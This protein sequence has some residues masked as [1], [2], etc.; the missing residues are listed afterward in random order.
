MRTNFEQSAR[1]VA[2]APESTDSGR[3]RCE[4]GTNIQEKTHF[5]AGVRIR[6]VRIDGFGASAGA[7]EDE[8]RRSGKSERGK[9]SSPGDTPLR[10]AAR[11]PNQRIRGD[12]GAR[13]GREELRKEKKG[14]R[15]KR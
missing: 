15:K 14:T 3:I 11:S 5:A 7:R 13:V 2:G 9:T 8:K 6:G 4:R 10:F 1:F 12:F